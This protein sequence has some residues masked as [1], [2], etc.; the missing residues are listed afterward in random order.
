MWVN[1]AF[2]LQSEQVGNLRDNT[3]FDG[4]IL[5]RVEVVWFL[6]WC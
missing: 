2:K 3:T 1:C 6:L 4:L 5:E